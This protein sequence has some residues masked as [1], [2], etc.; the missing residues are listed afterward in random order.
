M[1]PLRGCDPVT[2]VVLNLSESG[3]SGCPC[4]P[5]RGRPKGNL[6]AG[7]ADA[8]SFGCEKACFCASDGGSAAASPRP[9]SLSAPV[10]REGASSEARGSKPRRSE[11]MISPWRFLIVTTFVSRLTMIV[12]WMLAKI[13]LFAGGIT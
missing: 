4:M 6:L 1:A 8:E 7:C 11:V 13:A 12:L 5:G 3:G 9:A 2:G 10:L